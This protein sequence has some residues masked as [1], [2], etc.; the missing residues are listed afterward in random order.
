MTNTSAAVVERAFGRLPVVLTPK[1]L[2]A[3]REAAPDEYPQYDQVSDL[4]TIAEKDFFEPLLLQTPPAS[5]AQQF[6]YLAYKYTPIRLFVL[7]LLKN[8]PGQEL[9]AFCFDPPITSAHWLIEPPLGLP[10]ADIV[11]AVGKYIDSA[12]RLVLS[13]PTLQNVSAKDVMQLLA[14]TTEVDFG[15]TALEFVFEGTI[16]ANDWVVT[17][18]FTKTRRAMLDYENAAKKISSDVQLDAAL[19]AIRFENESDLPGPSD[20]RHTFL[21]YGRTQ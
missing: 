6:E 18:T 19:E 17:E 5:F 21:R 7:S 14:P 16:Q 12:Q 9:A 20:L 2:A 4:L 15:L 11:A 10:K 13:V 1:K 3:C 8:V